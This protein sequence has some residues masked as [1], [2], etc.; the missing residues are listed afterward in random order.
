MRKLALLMVVALAA[1]SLAG[2]LKKPDA[3]EEDVE[4]AKVDVIL[5]QQG[6][7]KLTDAAAIVPKNYS[8]PGQSILP[9]VTTKFTGTV[10]ADATGSYEA[11]RDEGGIDYRTVVQT[12][13]VSNLV[14]PG[15]PVELVLTV[16]WDASE[17]NSADL[18]IVVDVPGTST[19]YSPVSETLNWNVASKTMVVN[20]VGVAGKPALVGVQVASGAVTQGFDYDLHV[21]ATYVKDVL[22]PHHAWALEV[23]QGAGGLVFESEK[24]GGEEHITAQFVLVDPEDNLVQFVDFNDIDIPTQSIFIPTS[25]AGTYVFYAYFMHGG[26]LRVKADVPLDVTAARTLALV[27]SSVADVTAPAPGVAG[28]DVLNGS[29]AQGTVPADDVNPTVVDFSPSGAFPLR[30][31]AYVSGQ[32][33]G[34]SKVTLKSP[35]GVVHQLTSIARYQDER[36]TIGYTSDHE[37]GPNNVVDWKNIQKGT[38]TAEIVNN[39]PG[40]EIGHVVLT[41]QR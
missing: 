18:D 1:A 24:A 25:R 19:S 40:V 35:L 36:G 5:G 34:M 27:E 28:K 39:S 7:D 23:P 15:Q 22:T 20:S 4:Q 11:E 31:T 30:V 6:K 2:C 8:F 37:G 33:T 3:P 12:Y 41:Y 38:W 14:P 21:Q 26:F 13:D 16:V 10:S 29:A 9:P 17:G 32:A